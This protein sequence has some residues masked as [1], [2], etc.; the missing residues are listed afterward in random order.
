M[1]GDQSSSLPGFFFPESILVVKG[2]SA[3]M[4]ERDDAMLVRKEEGKRRSIDSKSMHD[5]LPC[6]AVFC[7]FALRSERS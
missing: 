4:G 7:V 2:P 5:A 3:S 1:A 6:R